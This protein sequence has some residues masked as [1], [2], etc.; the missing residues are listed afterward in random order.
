MKVWHYGG[1]GGMYSFLLKIQNGKIVFKFL[2]CLTRPQNVRKGI[3]SIQLSLR[4]PAR[5][6]VHPGLC[7]GSRLPSHGRHPD[8]WAIPVMH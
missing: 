8:P 4:R 5:M 6:P 7:T 2:R 3:L 1:G